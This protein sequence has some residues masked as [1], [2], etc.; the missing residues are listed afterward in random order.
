MVGL[1]V[2]LSRRRAVRTPWETVQSGIAQQIASW[3]AL[4]AR[5]MRR[6]ERTWKPDLLVP[7][8]SVEEAG[9]L[10][11]V[12]RALI[13]VRGSVKFVAL[14]DDAELGAV[15]G[16]MVRGL[17]RRDQLATWHLMP[18]ESPGQG[19]RLS[20][21]ALQGAFFAPNLL[22]LSAQHTDAAV[23]Q[24]ALDHARRHRVGV[25]IA[26][27]S[28]QGSMRPCRSATVWLSDRAPE[29]ELALHVANLDLPVL[30]AYLLT[31][32]LSG[33]IR[34]VTV[35]REETH[36]AAAQQFMDDLIELGRLPRTTA[37]LPSGQL[38]AQLAQAMPTD[39]HVF[40]L[41][42]AI[43][44]VRMREIHANVG[45]PCLFVLDSGQESAL[46]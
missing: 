10:G 8:K 45:R 28:P 31:R 9:A 13:Q 44:L 21:N 41:S 46:A 39:V 30:L 24:D 37:H 1:Y 17:Q 27:D 11:A 6:S 19:A 23:L 32:P 26:V 25:V 4:R 38:D 5:Q 43:D 36:R 22:V 2:W 33:E 35:L 15:L 42:E 12:A 7:V 3:A 16:G 14:V 40:G 29:W 20:I 18:E 34:L